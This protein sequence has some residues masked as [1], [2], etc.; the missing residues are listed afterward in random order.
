MLYSIWEGDGITL[1]SGAEPPV[2]VDG[3]LQDPTARKVH[4]FHAD[5]WEAAKLVM[6]ARY[7]WQAPSDVITAEKATAAK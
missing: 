1:I 3:R 5:S 7:G 2:F 4:E 6:D